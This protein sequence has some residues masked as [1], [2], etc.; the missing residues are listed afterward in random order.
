MYSDYKLGNNSLCILVD[1]DIFQILDHTQ[2]RWK[3]VEGYTH[4]EVDS[5]CHD[6]QADK[7]YHRLFPYIQEDTGTGRLYD[8]IHH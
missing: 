5:H 6:S 7:L 1:S 2:S 4:T 8:D 3:Y